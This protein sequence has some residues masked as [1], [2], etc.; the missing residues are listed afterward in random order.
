MIPPSPRERLRKFVND[1]GLGDLDLGPLITDLWVAVAFYTR[2]PVGLAGPGDGAALARASWAAPLAGALVGAIGAIAYWIAYR[3]NLP[4]L[5][6]ATLAI[7]ATLIVTGALHEDGLADTA[8]GFG[9]GQ[10]RTQTLDIMRDS[11]I[12]TY[13]TCAVG[14]TL[15]LR[16]TALADVG[17]ARGP[18]LVAGALIAAHAAARATLPVFMLWVAPARSE[19]LSAGAGAPSRERAAVA[20]LIGVVLLWVTLGLR[21]AMIALVPLCAGTVIM[22]WLSRRKIGGQT[23]D[24]LGALEQ[25][26]E[27]VVLLVAAARF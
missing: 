8:D 19:G 22:A 3:L 23:G 24:V 10:T 13:G 14:L 20:A 18:A 15:V 25:V 5:V 16:I 9:G 4:P 26:G 11:R 1:L 21:N 17:D 12:G 27:C 6:C 7:G 2:I